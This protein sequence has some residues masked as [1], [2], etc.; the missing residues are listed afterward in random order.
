MLVSLGIVFFLIFNFIKFNKYST[1]KR[2][3]FLFFL[4]SLVF[5]LSSVLFFFW[6]FNIIAYNPGDLLFIY[7]ILTFFEAVLL[8]F[9]VYSLRK[10]KKIFYLL[11]I[12]LI[13]IISAIFGLNFS[14]FL[15]LSSFL[16]ILIIFILLLPIP[17]FTRMSKFAIFYSSLSLFLQ[18]LLLFWNRFLPAAILISNIFFFS[19]G[20]TE[21]HT[22]LGS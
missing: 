8:M 2:I 14:N 10:N 21:S 5:L 16:F 17:Y 7:S 13:F 11:F 18:I 22:S 3:F 12:Y 4:L 15:L 6:V 19:R 9:M 1:L 20:V